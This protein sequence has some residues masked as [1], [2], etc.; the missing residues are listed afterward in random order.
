MGHPSLSLAPGGI[1]ALCP[2]FFVQICRDCEEDTDGEIPVS[3][4][5]AD[6]I[7]ASSAYGPF[8][9]PIRAIKDIDN[10]PQNPYR[11]M[12]SILI[13]QHEEA[14]LSECLLRDHPARDDCV[15][16]VNFDSLDRG[17]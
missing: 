7:L 4:Y 2:N 3:N 13:D 15:L 14:Q 12:P 8:S 5:P 10:S 1:V 16:N 17:I 9:V 11:K 6:S